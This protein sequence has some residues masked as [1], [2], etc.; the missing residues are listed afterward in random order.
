MICPNQSNR[1]PLNMKKE[2]KKLKCGSLPTVDIDGA[3]GKI[4][5][6]LNKQ[7]LALLTFLNQELQNV[8][9][10][11]DIINKGRKIAVYREISR[12]RFNSYAKET[13]YLMLTIWCLLHNTL[14]MLLLILVSWYLLPSTWYPKLATCYLL[15]D[16]CYL[17]L[18]IRY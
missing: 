15:F 9:I 4:V 8:S 14:Y 1:G 11:T 13:C 2:K 7:L 12:Y 5:C 3:V 17:I 16:T 6:I 18:V 10:W